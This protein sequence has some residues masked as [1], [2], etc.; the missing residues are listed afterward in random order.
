MTSPRGRGGAIRS[1][2]GRRNSAR[3]GVFWSDVLIDTSVSSVTQISV[4]LTA[5]LTEQEL[6]KGMTLIRTIMHLSFALSAAGAGGNIV[7]GIAMIERDAGAA[8]AL[9]DPISMSDQLGWLWRDQISVFSSSTN[10]HS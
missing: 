8:G 7:L 4:E 1:S 10:D 3:R 9:P 2:F 5:N 6:I